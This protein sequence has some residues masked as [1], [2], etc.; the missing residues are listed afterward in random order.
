MRNPVVLRTA[1]W[2]QGGLGLPQLGERRA[3]RDG[4]GPRHGGAMQ[5]RVGDTSSSESGARWGPT[6]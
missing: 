6:M 5:R 4:Q 2:S 3:V 1:T